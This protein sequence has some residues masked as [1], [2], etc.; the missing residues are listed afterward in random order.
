MPAWPRMS[1]TVMQAVD[2]DRMLREMMRVTK[3]GGRIGVLANAVD[4]PQIINLP[5]RAELKAKAEA[6]RVVY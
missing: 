3:P 6:A 1:F 2:A 4:R 5:L